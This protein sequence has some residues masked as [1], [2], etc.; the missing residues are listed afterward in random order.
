M[1]RAAR[2]AVGTGNRFQN[3]QAG[4]RVVLT[5][6]DKRRSSRRSGRD[7][8]GLS[9]A[10]GQM[11][12]CVGLRNPVVRA[13]G[14]AGKLDALAVP[15]RERHFCRAVRELD[16]LRFIA[17]RRSVRS[18]HA[19]GFTGEVLRQTEYCRERKG[20]LTVSIC[21]VNRF[22]DGQIAAPH[23]GQISVAGRYGR[24]F[25]V[26]PALCIVRF[27]R[28]I[29]CRC[30]ID[31]YGIRIVHIPAIR[32]ALRNGIRISV[33]VR[34]VQRQVCIGV[35]PHVGVRIRPGQCDVLRFQINRLP[36]GIFR[37]RLRRAPQRQLQ[38]L[39]P[40]F[41]AAV[42]PCLC[43]GQRR[44][45]P[46]GDLRHTILKDIR[47]AVVRLTVC[48]LPVVF[49]RFALCVQ[50][51][52][53]VVIQRMRRIVF[54]KLRKRRFPVV[55]RVQLRRTVR[56]VC[57]LR[58]FRYGFAFCRTDHFRVGR[59]VQAN[60]HRRVFRGRLSVPELLY[61][62]R[63]AA[64]IGD[65][66]SGYSRFLCTVRRIGVFDC[67]IR[68]KYVVSIRNGLAH[69]VFE[70][71]ALFVV[72]IHIGISKRPRRLL[73]VAPLRFCVCN[74]L[75]FL[76]RTGRAALQRQLRLFADFAFPC[77][78]ALNIHR[79]DQRVLYRKRIVFDERAVPAGIVGL[80]MQNRF[81]AHAIPLNRQT[82]DIICV[83][84]YFTLRKLLPQA[85]R[86]VV[87]VPLLR[88]GQA[89]FLLVRIDVVEGTSV[90][91]P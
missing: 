1:E 72:L 84:I 13:A 86:I 66:Q 47:D 85:H 64:D 73:G 90:S 33:A 14:Q 44:D 16:R 24:R 18:V 2:F 12:V 35:G 76:R 88:A 36:N 26:F 89:D 42:H 34:R 10:C 67:A 69:T 28:L 39:R 58:I 68:V 3:A 82:K 49:D 40:R 6:V 78:G 60:L 29:Q 54:R 81:F 79:A 4:K 9:G 61:G 52:R 87:I 27:F 22:F 38:R 50:L 74:R 32:D 45:L 37:I 23:I 77:L 62:K 8:P 41:I 91:I 30:F 21:A 20:L 63:H 15:E 51:K 70:Q 65:L 43:T 5:R 56:A 31:G 71:H 80:I 11:P 53:I 55:L 59:P 25:S 7:F 17:A 48:D 19:V 83:A 46:V 75:P 57:S